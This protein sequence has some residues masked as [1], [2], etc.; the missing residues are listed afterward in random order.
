MSV[1]SAA[2]AP[3]TPPMPELD[4]D[5]ALLARYD[6]A[7]PRYTSYPTAPHFSTG[8]DERAYRAH[9]GASNDDPIP[10]PL[11][12]YL[13]M[14]FC[15]SPCFYCGCNRVITRDRARGEAYLGRLHR[16]VALQGALFDRDRRVVQLHLGGGTPNFF[17]L[18]QYE[19]LFEALESSFTFA[20]A[21]VREFSIEMDPRHADRDYVRA[22]AKLGF[23]RASLGVQDFDHAV[24]VA[25]NRVQSVKETREV[26]DAA[27]ESG[28]RSVSVDL[29]YGLP[30]QNLAGFGRTLDTVVGASPDRI[31]LY[32]YAHLPELFKAQRQIA[33]GDLPAPADKLALLGLAVERLGESGYRYIGMD[34]FARADDELARALDERTLQ[35]NFQGYSTHAE[36]DLVGLG[37]SA[38]GRVGDCYAQN[39]RDLVGYNAALDNGRLAIAKG[40]ELAAEDE[41]RAAVIQDVMCRGEVEYRAFEWRYGIEFDLHFARELERLAPLAADGLVELRRDGFTVTPR[42]RLLVRLVAMAFD[43]YLSRPSEQRPRFSRVI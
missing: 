1:H 16:E 32:S 22:L 29:I 7:G 15:A 6:H 34:H 33:A 12:L 5:A 18:E 4:F 42:G 40:F 21:E 23:N 28:Y 24:Q 19:R 36:C 31:A 39:A 9:A 35:R 30:K 41:L 10:R 26:I 8:F 13:H 37:V 14:P 20:P 2:A 11:S 25:I 38:I 43:A 27:R 3:T 17:D